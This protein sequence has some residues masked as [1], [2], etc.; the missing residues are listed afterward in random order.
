MLICPWAL[1]TVYTIHVYRVFVPAY[2][3]YSPIYV[4]H[5]FCSFVSLSSLLA[6]NGSALRSA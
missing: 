1:N 2:F 6:S 3:T 4:F 5:G